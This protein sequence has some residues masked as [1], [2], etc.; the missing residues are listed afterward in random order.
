[1]WLRAELAADGARGVRG[2][3]GSSVAIL[4]PCRVEHPLIGRPPFR[5]L[6]EKFL[7]RDDALVDKQLRQCVGFHYY[8]LATEIKATTDIVVAE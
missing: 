7:L 1:M 5:D 2:M 6:C 3:Q 4:L 8:V